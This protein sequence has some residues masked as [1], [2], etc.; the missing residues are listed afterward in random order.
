ME[1][2]TDLPQN[3]IYMEV[4]RPYAWEATSVKVIDDRTLELSFVDGTRGQA[5]FTDEALQAEIFSG[6]KDPQLFRQAYVDEYGI[7]CWPG[8]LDISSEYLHDEIQANGLAVV[9]SD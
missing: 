3:T 4:D 5:V 2:L 8:D 7:V 1:A 9:D 6:L